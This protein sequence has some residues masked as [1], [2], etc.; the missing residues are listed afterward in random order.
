MNMYGKNIYIYIH[1][2]I[3][4]LY[5]HIF[6][7]YGSLFNGSLFTICFARYKRRVANKI[8]NSSGDIATM[9]ELIVCIAKIAVPTL[10]SDGS[11]VPFVPP[12][13][14]I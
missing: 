14:V 1:V 12:K 10:N 8:G 11:A 7:S 5:V 3:F 9:S 2:H 13:K 4:Y 6:S